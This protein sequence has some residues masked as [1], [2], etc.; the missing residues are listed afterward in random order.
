MPETTNEPVYYGPCEKCGAVHGGWETCQMPAIV[1]AITRNVERALSEA[2]DG[3][4][5]LYPGEARWILAA[6]RQRQTSPTAGEPETERC[7]CRAVPLNQC[8]CVLA[9][10]TAAPR[11]TGGAA[12]AD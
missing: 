12:D 6:L 10:P 8:G 2:G 5:T 4:V 11:G 3:A 9:A 1:A 7:P